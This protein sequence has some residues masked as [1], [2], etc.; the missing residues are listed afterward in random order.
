MGAVAALVLNVRAEWIG[1]VLQQGGDPCGDERHIP[2][3]AVRRGL[4]RVGDVARAAGVVVVLRLGR[5]AVDRQSRRQFQRRWWRERAGGHLTLT[6][7]TLAD[8]FAS[9]SGGIANN[10]GT[11]TLT[12]STVSGNFA[13]SLGGIDNFSGG[14]ATL[15]NTIL[16]GN[17]AV[18][19]PDCN[20]TLTSDDYN[21]IQDTT[22][23]AII[24][25]VAE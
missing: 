4:G 14:T 3:R 1:L 2:R 19:G 22:E 12:N 7:L 24:R 16:A 13:G 8:G 11:L 15:R 20:G 23:C 9:V 5:L 21:L 18:I 10:G 6:A 25:L 17:H